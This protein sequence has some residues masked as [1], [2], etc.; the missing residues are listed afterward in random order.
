MPVKASI[1]NSPDRPVGF[2]ERDIWICSIGE[3][4]GFEE[5]GKGSKFARPVLILRTYGAFMCHVVPL[6]TTPKRGAYYY[7]FDGGT[8]K[9]SVALLT[10]SK[11]I[12]SSRLKRKIGVIKANDFQSIKRMIRALLR[13]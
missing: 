8:G 11:V 1:N 9:E 12:D 6:S 10:Q 2:R 4:V 7:L 5:D 3:N 13:L